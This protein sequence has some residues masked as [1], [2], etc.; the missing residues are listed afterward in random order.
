MTSAYVGLP[1]SG[2]SYGVVENVIIPA[3]R[4]GRALW[5]NI[6][7]VMDEIY[8]DFPKADV[9]SFTVDDI[10]SNEKWFSEVLPKG[11]VLV[12]DEVWDLWPCG[13]KVT[14]MVEGHKEILAKHRHMVLN[15]NTT[16]IVLVTQNL[17]QICSFARELIDTTFMAKKMS[18]I[19]FS[20]AYRIDVYTGAVTGQRPPE[21]LLMRQI[22][23]KYR[24]KVY[25]YYV[26]HTQS[27]DGAG[28]ETRSDSRASVLKGSAVFFIVAPFILF[29][30]SYYFIKDS[31][32][33]GEEVVEVVKVDSVDSLDKI[34]VNKSVRAEHEEKKRKSSKKDV[35]KS[36]P[37]PLLKGSLYI[38]SNMTFGMTPH[39]IISVED[40][41]RY[42]EF[43]SKQIKRLG[44]SISY[45]SQCLVKIEIKTVQRYAYC[46]RQTD[47]D[48]VGR[49]MTSFSH[50]SE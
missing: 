24:K 17:N 12:I 37:N 44:G 32:F 39:Y 11:V 40:G 26:S 13:L 42:A 21:H 10:K 19:G 50:S 33:P 30:L 16:E 22:P 36:D 1:G 18:S 3:L 35:Y 47:V 43:D 4:K 9:T 15:G 45:I 48:I 25:K 34:S 8:N 28:D 14:N 6:P 20:K 46:K 27:D 29:P 31:L 5:T 38:T 2:K 41:D 49:G 7:L 23:G